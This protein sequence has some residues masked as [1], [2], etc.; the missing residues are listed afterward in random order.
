MNKTIHH[1]VN[2]I[3]NAIDVHFPTTGGTLKANLK[4]FRDRYG[5]D[6]VPTAEQDANL[7]GIEN[8]LFMR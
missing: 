4:I 7:K 5:C 3:L 8:M 6:A 1:R 2:V